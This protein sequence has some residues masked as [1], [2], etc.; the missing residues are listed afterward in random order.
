MRFASTS[1]VSEDPVPDLPTDGVSE[2][3]VRSY[4]TRGVSEAPC[5]IIPSNIQSSNK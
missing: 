1:R 3:P 4:S 5:Q 2:D